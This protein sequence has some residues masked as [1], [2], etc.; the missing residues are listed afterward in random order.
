M[1]ELSEVGNAPR[2][3]HLDLAELQTILRLAFVG[4]LIATGSIAI[5]VCRQDVLMWRQ[6][7]AQEPAI[8]EVASKQQQILVILGELQKLGSKYPDYATNVLRSFN[9]APASSSSLTNS[10]PKR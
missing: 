3:S 7:K 1:N 2:D 10:P 5:L 8:A 9:L 4:T 6:I